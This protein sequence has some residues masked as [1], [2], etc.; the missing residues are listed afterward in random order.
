[1]DTT[2]QKDIRYLNKDFVSFRK[3]LMDF[4]K[5]YYPDSYSDFNESSLG[6][7]FMEMAS[8]VG[9]VLS[10][11]LDSNLK[12]SILL[13]AEERKNIINL[14]Q[15]FG[16]KY[17]T[18]I[19]GSTNV[20]VYQIIPS[21]GV[22]GSQINTSF[23][24]KIDAGMIVGSDAFSNVQFRT[25]EPV[26][27]SVFNNGNFQATVYTLDGSG[28]VL[29]Y[30]IKKTVPAVAG[31]IS[32][33]DFTF[34]DPVKYQSVTIPYPDVIEILDVVDSDGNQWYE[35]GY[36][37]Q[38]TIWIDEPNDPVSNTLNS[39]NYQQTPRILK[40]KKVANRYTTRKTVDLATELQFGS[41][42]SSYPDQVL[43]PTPQTLQY[44]TN[45]VANSVASNFLNTNTYGHIPSNT[46]LTV[47]F[48]RGG[49]IQSNVPQNDLTR[50]MNYTMQNS[51]NDYTTAADIATFNDVVKSVATS[52][53]QPATGGRGA[54]TEDEIRQNAIAYFYSQDR[55]VTDRDY[56]IKTLTLPA[57]YGSVSKAYV[58][59]TL[60]QFSVDLYCLG[61]DSNKKLIILNDAT[62]Q[63]LANYLYN[64]REL[65]TAVNIK[66]AY[67]VNIGVKFAVLAYQ[68]YNKHDVLV[69]C[70]TSLQ[71]YFNIDK[72]EIG[73]PI[74]VADLYNLLSI[75]PGV[76]SVTDVTISNLFSSI[77]DTTYSN[78]YYHIPAATLD[79]IIYPSQDP[80]IFEV[81]YPNTDIEGTIK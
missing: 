9:D 13:Y 72:W 48:T 74:I 16:Y 50:V 53:P 44:N 10:F 81:K 54:E 26:D 77:G 25:T 67:V 12:E 55:C 58:R 7:M 30:L 14:A 65:T 46:T 22:K 6:M 24:L 61:Y 29:N 42:V 47:R 5:I 18:T 79:G 71:N 8:Y 19:P 17:K 43:I 66:N 59:R 31:T 56:L 11:Y 80:S 63:N 41:G 64:Y 70:I 15:T 36:L 35:V 57:K 37:A 76:R 68:Q 23:A 73:Q 75:V 38:D 2:A 21:F 32:T 69:S 62:K 33:I 4:A 52:N 78:I 39:A 60:G 28:N 1:M 49:G 27:F 34:G 51:V 45:F 40:M 3:A 20:D